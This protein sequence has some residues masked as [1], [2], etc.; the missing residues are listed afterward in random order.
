MLL[1]ESFQLHQQDHQLIQLSDFQIDKETSFSSQSYSS[2]TIPH[3]Y[4]SLEEAKDGNEALYVKEFEFSSPEKAKQRF[5]EIKDLPS[6]YAGNHAVID[7]ALLY[8]YYDDEIVS[9]TLLHNQS[10]TIIIPSF[11]LTEENI[12]I[13]SQFYA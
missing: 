1:Y 13:I 10:V 11:P 12:Q 8:G 6:L 9:L 3:T 4:I 2:F 5:T 7:G